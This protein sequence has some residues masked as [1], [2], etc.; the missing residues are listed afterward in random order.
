MEQETMEAVA[1]ESTSLGQEAAYDLT[2]WGLFADADLVVQVVLIML[3]LASRTSRR[4][5]GPEDRST[6]STS[7]W[8][9]GRTTPCRRSSCRR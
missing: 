8:I 9:S 6:T 1:V 4:I 7:R 2:I 5:S 3:L